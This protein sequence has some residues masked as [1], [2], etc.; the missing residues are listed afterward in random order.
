MEKKFRFISLE[1][2]E[3]VRGRAELLH[4]GREGTGTNFGKKRA[5]KLVMGKRAGAYREKKNGSVQKKRG[6]SGGERGK[7]RTQKGEER[8]GRSGS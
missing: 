4:T 6:S 1:K 5:R 7:W 8:E 3:C 2:E